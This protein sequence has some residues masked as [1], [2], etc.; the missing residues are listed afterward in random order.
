MD[1]RRDTEIA[2]G[3]YQPK[4][5]ENEMSNGEVHAYRMSLWYEHTNRI[6]DCYLEPQSLDCV[7]MIRAVGDEMW[8]VYSGEE[9]VDMEG[10]HL[11]TYPIIVS[12]DGSIED[13]VEG[14]GTFPDTTTPIRGKRSMVLPAVCTT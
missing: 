12:K 2:M 10:T 4:Y 14:G 13:P 5:V 11:V 9:V 3:C 6:D 1:G 8:S 7:R